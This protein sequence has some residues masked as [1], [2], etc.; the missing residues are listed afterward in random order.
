MKRAES[1][2]QQP[3]GGDDTEGGDEADAW[4]ETKEVAEEEQEEMATL[5]EEEG[6]GT[7]A[8]LA[9]KDKDEDD[10][11]DKDEESDDDEED[12]AAA[13][14]EESAKGPNSLSEIAEFERLLPQS[15]SIFDLRS[16]S[17]HKM[18]WGR[19]ERKA[20]T[21]LRESERQAKR[22]KKPADEEQDGQPPNQI[23]MIDFQVV[24]PA[25]WD[26]THWREYALE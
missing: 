24:W 20:N 25:R 1:N 5:E 18:N 10:D 12:A 2:N 16:R 3:G 26:W 23:Q 6:Q 8:G 21:Q 7:D 15:R 14:D 13:A 22:R 9:G 4:A 19:K 11:E 17:W